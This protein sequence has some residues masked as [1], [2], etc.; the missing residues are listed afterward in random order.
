M[1]FYRLFLTLLA[2]AI[3]L[4]LLVRVLRG[5]ESLRDFSE[6]LGLWQNLPKGKIVWL[7]GASNGELT[8]ARPVILGIATQQPDAKLLITCNSV[9]ARNMVQEWGLA[10]VDVRLAPLDLRRTY[11]RIMARLNLVQFILFEADF[12]PNRILATRQLNIPIA[13]IG[14]RISSKS[15]KGWARFPSLSSAVF[16]CFDLICAQ[17]EASE[18]RLLALGARLQ[19]IGPRIA[20]KSFYSS[21]IEPLGHEQRKNTWLA[22]ST[23]EGEDEILLRAHLVAQKTLPDLRMI[24]APRHPKRAV[25]IM[26]TAKTLG[27]KVAQRSN[28]GQIG[29]ECDVF[30]TDTLGEMNLWYKAAG[31]CF[32]AGS[33]VP[34]G[35]HT[36]FEPTFHNCALLHGPYLENFAEPYADLQR[37]DGALLCRN[38]TEIAAAI[39]ELQTSDPADTLRANAQNVLAESQ[40]LNPVLIALDRLSKI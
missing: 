38:A 39:I 5:Q 17:D 34:K 13:L 1:L 32:V 37:N 16:T 6:R 29:D 18:V 12:W 3:A 36:P 4:A 22:A 23:H 35:G 27:L 31:V 24:L 10:Q 30:L 40:N 25:E 26:Q 8:A 21:T 19:A 20:L 2:P 15:A 9:S 28:G 33:L 14:G 11:R 7:H